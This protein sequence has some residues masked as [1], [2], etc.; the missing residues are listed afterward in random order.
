MRAVWDYFRFGCGFRRNGMGDGLLRALI[1]VTSAH[2]RLRA[3]HVMRA[4]ETAALPDRVLEFGFGEGY[5]LLTMAGRHPGVRFEGVEIDPGHVDR[6]TAR[7]LAAG[8]GNAAFCL[9]DFRGKSP[10]PVYGLIY[11]ADVLEHV[12]D[13]AALAAFLAH[14]LA[15]GGRLVVH[16]P[17]TRSRQRRFLSKFARHT[18]P[19]HVREEYSPEALHDLLT[20]QGLSVVDM[21]G[22]FGPFGE[23]AFELNSLGWPYA[24][25]D[26]AVRTATI[27]PAAIL[28]LGD[29]FLP[30][31]W[32]NSILAVA[33]KGAA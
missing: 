8:L 9:E 23:A 2:T 6:A 28:G 10:E 33:V 15:P 31:P 7:A 25:L 4:L 3:L 22:T 20:G 17:L 26:R 29:V 11:T 21:H 1:G 19:G 24:G 16:V 12:P 27:L 13:D 14:S 30:R 32:G 18:D 5:L